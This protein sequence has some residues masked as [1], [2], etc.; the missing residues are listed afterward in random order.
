[1]GKSAWVWD[2]PGRLSLAL[3]CVL[4]PRSYPPRIIAHCSSAQA[5]EV[6][7]PSPLQ[8]PRWATPEPAHSPLQGRHCPT[9]ALVQLPEAMEPRA[10]ARSKAALWGSESEERSRVLTEC[11]SGL[12][13]ST[14][15]TGRVF[16]PPWEGRRRPLSASGKMKQT[17]TRC[18]LHLSLKIGPA[19]GS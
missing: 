7:T 5:G 13:L 12:V 6:G 16:L 15:K 11:P 1:M 9:L 18:M 2:T 4:G 3:A 10:Q 8:S 17:P 14:W 19:Q